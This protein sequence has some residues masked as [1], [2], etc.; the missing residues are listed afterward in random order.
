MDYYC[1]QFP[2]QTIIGS[3]KLNF[4]HNEDFLL[5]FYIT[6]KLYFK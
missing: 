6:N 3:K 4:Y 1:F 5:G 2:I